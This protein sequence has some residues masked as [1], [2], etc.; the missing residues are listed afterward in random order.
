MTTLMNQIKRAIHITLVWLLVACFIGS[1]MAQTADC[2]D[3]LARAEDDYKKGRFEE[4]IVL[5][6]SCLEKPDLPQSERRKAYRL[7]GLTYLA[8]DYRDQAKQA[9]RQLLLLVPDYTSDPDQDPPPFSR[10]VE[11]MRWE[12]YP[13]ST[14]PVS[15]PAEEK[16]SKKKWYLIALGVLVAGAVI[17]LLASSGDSDT[18]PQT[19]ENPPPLP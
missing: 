12:M 2:Q 10:M 3:E 16:S 8:Q 14:T 4:A 11:E 5:L 15:E 13:A 9:V 19:I 6:E 18:A 17:A 7:L 1:P